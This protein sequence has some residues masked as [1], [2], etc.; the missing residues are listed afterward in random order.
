MTNEIKTRTGN[1]RDMFVANMAASY[2]D[3]PEPSYDPYG[4]RSD[5]SGDSKNDGI[6]SITMMVL[7]F[8]EIIMI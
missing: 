5:T 3:L 2:Y 6:L 1:L 8:E 4:G 7:V